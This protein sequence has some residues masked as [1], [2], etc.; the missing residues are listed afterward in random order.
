MGLTDVF[1]KFLNRAPKEDDNYL[2]LT[3]T[4]EKIIATIWRPLANSVE[5]VG[6]SEKKFNNIDS[7]IHEAAAAIDSAAKNI[8]SDVSQVVFGLSNYWFEDGKPSGETEEVLKSL[9]QNLDL[10]AQAFVPLA[11]SQSHYLGLKGES[12]N[13]VFIGAFENYTEVCLINNGVVTSSEY[14]GKASHEEIKRLLN[15]LQQNAP[16]DLPQNVVVIGDNASSLIKDL[17]KEREDATFTKGTKFAILTNEELGNC[18]A[19]SQ[20]AD[21]LGTEPQ[22]AGAATPIIKPT[23]DKNEE[24][25]VQ[26]QDHKST[27]DG[28]GE[29]FDFKEGKDVL[30]VEKTETLEASDHTEAKDKEEDQYAVDITEKTDVYEAPAQMLEKSKIGKKKSITESL[31]TLNWLPKLTGGNKKKILVVAVV[32][33]VALMAAIYI[34]GYT[35]TNVEVIIRANSKPFED[36]FDITVASGAALDTSRSRIPGEEITTTVQENSQAQATGTEKTGNNA[37][38]EVKVFNWTTSKVNFDKGSILISKNGIKFLL[39]ST[40]EVASRSA[41]TPGETAVQVTAED[42]GKSGNLA[43]GAEFTFKQHDELLYSAKNDNAFSGGDEKEI[44]VVTKDDQD[45]LAEDLEETLTKKAR[46]ELQQKIQGQNISDD[47]I[48]IKVVEKKFS[49]EIGEEATN[50]TL[51]MKVEASA[52]TYSEDI[53]KEFLAKVAQEEVEG[54]SQSRQ[55]N[56]DILELDTSRNKGNLILEGKFRANLVPKIDADGIK[57]QIAG[58]SQKSARETIKLNPEIAQVEFKLSPNLIIFSS[59]P[60]SK[61]KIKVTIEAI[62]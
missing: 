4:P 8:T 53:L 28:P 20:A 52:L 30:E 43:S 16:G 10:D 25:E 17:E 35:L 45:Q 2:S 58:K 50:F 47:A 44:T 38:G 39:D 55:E 54:D 31:F 1:G 24:S 37:K 36:N 14:K 22:L 49:A 46:D 41:A 19:Y 56:I 29:P 59:I 48:E 32:L 6:F 33:A 42:F 21:V 18:I 57:S 9:A 5:F 40:I 26:H 34:I 51:N 23:P 27:E 15:K 61:D 13:A 60:K 7:L 12:K 3:L 11:A 62:K